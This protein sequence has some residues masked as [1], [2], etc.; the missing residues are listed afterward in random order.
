MTWRMSKTD[1]LDR[2]GPLFTT[3]IADVRLLFNVPDIMRALW[4]CLRRF[5]RTG[6]RRPKVNVTVNYTVTDNC[7]SNTCTLSVSSNE[8]LNGTGDSD[9]APDWE[10]VDAHHVRLRAERA[11][12]GA[13]RI[14]AVTI[15]CRDSAG[16]SSSGWARTLR[17]GQEPACAPGAAEGNHTG[18]LSR[19]SDD[20]RPIGAI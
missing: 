3:M 9:T 19:R 5:Q 18:R 8:P 4:G 20:P 14:Y 6:G 7:G 1:S 17:H 12:T 10:I 15:T 13:G 2:V 16:N 11:G